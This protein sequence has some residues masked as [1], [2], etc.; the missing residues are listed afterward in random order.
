MVAVSS[1][2]VVV[3]MVMV[4]PLDPRMSDTERGTARPLVGGCGRVRAG[5]QLHRHPVE[6][7]GE[8]L[9]LGRDGLPV[10]H[11]QLLH[12]RGVRSP[13]GPHITILLVRRLASARSYWSAD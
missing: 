2:M 9:L 5:D 1:V 4:V 7:H 12:R 10:L 13:I 6:V 11:G 8:A 3:V